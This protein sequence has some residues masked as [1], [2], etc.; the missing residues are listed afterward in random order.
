MVAGGRVGEG[1]VREFEKNRYTRLYLKW[2]TRTSL[3]AQEVRN[4]PWVR[5]LN[6]SPGRFHMPQDN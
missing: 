5:W 4:P 3:M 6:L 2:I 1:R